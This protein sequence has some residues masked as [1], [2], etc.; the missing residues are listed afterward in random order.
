MLKPVHII[1][2]LVYAPTYTDQRPGSVPI[3]GRTRLMKMLFLYDKEISKGF[4]QNQKVNFGF[5]SYNYGPFSRKVYEAID[6][7]ESRGIIDV[8]FSNSVDESDFTL[9][10]LINSSDEES[11][12][13]DNDIQEESIGVEQFEI[14]K[15]GKSFMENQSKFF[16]WVNLNENQKEILK[17]FKS[18][19][20]SA[21][22]KDILRY[23]YQKYPEFA[24]KSIIRQTLFI[25]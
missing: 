2:L 5:K 20:V 16:A 22:L 25:D 4:Y 14:T 10:N 24:D 13:D 17:K 9:E 11:E 19:M 6:F 1:H 3:I 21:K 8:K 15:L 23:V 7:L 12:K 18:Q